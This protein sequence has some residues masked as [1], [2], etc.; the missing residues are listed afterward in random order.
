LSSKPKRKRTV[1]D[2]LK[3][4]IM[5]TRALSKLFRAPAYF[6]RKA[7]LVWQKQTCNRRVRFLQSYQPKRRPTSDA[8]DQII[9][10]L[11]LAL[12]NLPAFPIIAVDDVDIAWQLLMMVC[13]KVNRHVATLTLL[14]DPNP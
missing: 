11:E 12:G 2:H 6:F 7:I 10:R 14:G 3:R 4:E 1:C 9:G 5:L 13:Q 8:L